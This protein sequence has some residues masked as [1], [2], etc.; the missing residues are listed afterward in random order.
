MSR[1]FFAQVANFAMSES[2]LDLMIESGKYK[3]QFP[4]YHWDN[5]IS[6][7]NLKDRH[8][9]DYKRNDVYKAGIRFV[10]QITR[11]DNRLQALAVRAGV[12]SRKRASAIL[13][14]LRYYE[15]NMV[16]RWKRY[17]KIAAY[18]DGKKLEFLKSV[19]RKIH[20]R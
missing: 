4:G 10:R 14:K 7:T 15:P 5:P 16:T 9:Y 8:L 17:R 2:R 1:L 18:K 11:T 19:H 6:I 3:V 12:S 13:H 20:S